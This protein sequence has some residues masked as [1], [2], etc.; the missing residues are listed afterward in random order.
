MEFA[1]ISSQG[2]AFNFDFIID[3]GKKKKRKHSSV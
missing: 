3:F 1:S 2:Q